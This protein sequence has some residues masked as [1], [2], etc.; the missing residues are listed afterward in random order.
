MSR[1]SS[2]SEA[3]GFDSPY[4]TTYPISEEWGKQD[5]KEKTGSSGHLLKEISDKIVRLLD[6]GLENLDLY[7]LGVYFPNS[8]FKS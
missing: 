5:R 1:K 8:I 3:Y 2:E 7:S 6:F 4:P